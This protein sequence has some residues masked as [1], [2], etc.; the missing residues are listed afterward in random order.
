[1]HVEY[2]M[3]GRTRR[4][5][6]L[7]IAAIGLLAMPGCTW[8]KMRRSFLYT[9]YSSY[10]DGYSADRFSDFNRRYDEQAKAAE[11]YYQGQ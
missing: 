3:V 5:I 2:F 8:D 4:Y 9:I 6:L 11:E 7:L 10:G 1:M